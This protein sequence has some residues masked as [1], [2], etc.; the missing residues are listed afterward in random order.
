MAPLVLLIADPR[1]LLTEDGMC[2]LSETQAR[3]IL[4]LRLARLTA[5]GREEIAELL[6]K[7]AV[8]IAEFL[9]ILRSRTKLFGIIVEEMTAFRAAHAT[10]RKHRNP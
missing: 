3:A 6:N 9:E 2:R 10:P 8:E 4:E 1:H 5:L 7:L